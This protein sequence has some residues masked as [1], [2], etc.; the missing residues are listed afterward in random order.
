VNAVRRG[1]WT[2]GAP[3]RV[4]LIGVI[5]VYRVALSGIFG[6][7][8]RFEPSCSAYADEAIRRH[9][10][11]RGSVLAFWRVLRCNPFG[12]PGLDPVPPAPRYDVVVRPAV[13][14]ARETA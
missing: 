5:V 6:G 7:R 3:A 1:L 13:G 2:A 14:K 11:V 8:C 4:A 9:G 10:A 12:R